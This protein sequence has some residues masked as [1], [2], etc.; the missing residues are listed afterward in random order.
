[1]TKKTSKDNP[2]KRITLDSNVASAIVTQIA[3]ALNVKLHTDKDEDGNI[4]GV[5]AYIGNC[6]RLADHKTYLQTWVDN[7]MWDAPYR[8]SIVI[9]DEETIGKTQVKVGYD[10][11][12]LEYIFKSQMMTPQKAREIAF[13]IK[14]ARETGRFANNGG[15]QKFTLKSVY[16]T[17]NKVQQNISMNCTNDAVPANRYNHGADFVSESKNNK[18]NKN[19]SKNMNKK[20]T[21]RLTESGLKRIITESVKKVLQE[22]YV[23]TPHENKELLPILRERSSE[24][25][26]MCLEWKK[27]YK[28][29][30]PQWEGEESWYNRPSKYSD[31]LDAIETLITELENAPRFGY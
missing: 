30:Y 26:K 6:I 1:M 18:T 20:N 19:E 7:G 14:Q 12:V 21:I 4:L 23:E 27:L 13:D 29:V 31:V 10:F 11:E 24:L 16:N 22:D 2:I 3:I 15:G 8:I 9:E 17:L 28:Q 5:S 25:R